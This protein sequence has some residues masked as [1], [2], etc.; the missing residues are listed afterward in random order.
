MQAMLSYVLLI[1]FK[2]PSPIIE[3]CTQMFKKRLALASKLHK[4]D[5]QVFL[6]PL[7]IKQNNSP[8]RTEN[9]M[10]CIMMDMTYM[11]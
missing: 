9:S 2:L 4:I 5:A 6:V 11:I 3:P 10:A 1:Y 8:I 7:V